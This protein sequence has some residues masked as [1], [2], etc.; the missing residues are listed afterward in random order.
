MN[1]ILIAVG[2][3]A[4]IGL[5]I[6]LILSVASIVMAVPKNEKA[7]ALTA[8]LP[9][10]NCGA[11]GFSGCAGY[12]E[13]LA[14]GKAEVGLCPVGGEK[15]AA[16][17]AAVLGIEAGSVEKKVAVV[18]CMGSLDNTGYKADYSGLKSCAAALKIGGGLTACSYGCMGLGDCEAA[19]PYDAIRV[20]NGVA[21]VDPSK[22]RAC[23]LCVKACPRRIIALAPYRDQAVV[24]CSNHDKGALTR[25]LCTAGCI[26]CKKCEK[27]CGQGAV[28]VVDFCAYVT[29]ALCT[30]CGACVAAC[31][32]HCITD[33]KA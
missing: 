7:E 29:P 24:R 4:G 28:T 2:L 31:P 23:S 17:C 11:C 20:C 25:K 22:C 27:A 14:K 5:L 26:G 18:R 12:A 8:V 15:C 33:F 19:C 16:D 9:G 32:Q 30:G 21:V 3:V 10:A 13:A 6:G 1:D